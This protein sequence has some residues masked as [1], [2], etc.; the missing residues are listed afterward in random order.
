M[1]NNGDGKVSSIDGTNEWLG[2]DMTD[3]EMDE[4]C[5]LLA[6]FI[7]DIRN[8]KFRGIAIAGIGLS[9]VGC[10]YR[11]CHMMRAG[12]SKL[13]LV[14]AVHALSSQLTHQVNIEGEEEEEG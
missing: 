14:G 1:E 4:M 12:C 11:I 6:E 9:G 8:Q 3:E 5:A 10:E 7:R 13:G 2:E